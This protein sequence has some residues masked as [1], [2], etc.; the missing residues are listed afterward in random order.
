[1]Y[2]AF[3]TLNNFWNYC[4]QVL[5]KFSNPTFFSKLISALFHFFKITFIVFSLV[6]IAY[7]SFKNPV[8]TIPNQTEKPKPELNFAKDFEPKNLNSSKDNQEKNEQNQEISQN[9]QQQ[10]DNQNSDQSQNQAEEINPKSEDVNLK[11]EIPREN[12]LNKNELGDDLKSPENQ[13]NRQPQNPPNPLENQDKNPENKTPDFQKVVENSLQD[14]IKKQKLELYASIFLTL[15]LITIFYLS[16]KTCQ[17][18]TFY[19]LPQKLIKKKQWKDLNRLRY[20]Y[21]YEYLNSLYTFLPSWTLNEFLEKTNEIKQKNPELYSNLQSFAKMN[22][23]AFYGKEFDEKD[24]QISEILF[25]KI[26]LDLQKHFDK[27]DLKEIHKKVETAYFK[28]QKF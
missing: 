3:L 28:V 16:F 21:I 1:M 15:I 12:N 8:I 5:Y 24:S 23:K 17:N 13:Q 7:F 27:K 14:F 10:I 4:K 20:L 18:I 26:I 2:K 22:N 11:T 9:L 19:N 6:F 25:A